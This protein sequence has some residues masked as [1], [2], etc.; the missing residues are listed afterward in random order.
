MGRG[1]ECWSFGQIC[2]VRDG[3]HVFRCSKHGETSLLSCASCADFSPLIPLLE[4]RIAGVMQTVPG[5]KYFRDTVYAFRDTVDDHCT[6][7]D[8][9]RLGAFPT[10][11]VAMT[12]V[13]QRFPHA[14]A[15]LYLQ[16]D[17]MLSDGTWAVL[18]DEWQGW[19]VCSLYNPPGLSVG[20]GWQ[21]I[22][23]GWQSPGA[24]CYVFSPAALRDLLSW[25]YLHWH[26]R[27]GPNNG[28][29]DIDAVVG[30]WASK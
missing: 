8:D 18:R 9:D 14:S 7:V 26:R 1:I 17:T 3:E 27:M 22:D 21:Q 4:S 25:E 24:C 12:T 16:D 30:A 10:F 11:V 23:N 15:Y 5:R 19:P 2:G 28:T 29:R 6:V 13:A 20:H